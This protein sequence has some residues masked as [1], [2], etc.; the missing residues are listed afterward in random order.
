FV[1]GAA[2]QWLRDGLQL[3]KSSDEIEK[4]AQEVET[5]EGVSFVPALVGLGAPHWKPEARGV[6]CGL[7]RGTKKSHI[8]YATLEAMA[9]QNVEILNG[10]QKELGQKIKN[11]K[12]DGGASKN[13]LLMQM[14]SDFSGLRVVRPQ[15]QETTVMGAAYLAGLGCGM[16]KD[17]SQIKSLWFIEK[18]F[19]SEKSKVWRTQR[20]MGWTK[21]V[22]KSF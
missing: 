3:I 10:M 9:L 17:L 18:E 16:W 5:S 2:V 4:L 19:K 12:V 7:H 1:C 6:I 21:A 15:N 14:Q 13:N 11:V 22:K 8:A 20:L